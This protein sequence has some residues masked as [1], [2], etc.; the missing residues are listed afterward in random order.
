MTFKKLSLIRTS[1]C[2]KRLNWRVLQ[3]KTNTNNPN[4]QNKICSSGGHLGYDRGDCGGDR[5]ADLLLSRPI[6]PGAGEEIS[7]LGGH[8]ARPQVGPGPVPV[9]SNIPQTTEEQ[10]SEKRRPEL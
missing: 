10:Q 6:L 5:G 9:L 3:V 8:G 7:P 2:L 4:K 1:T